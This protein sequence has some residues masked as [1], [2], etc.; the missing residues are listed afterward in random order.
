[1]KVPKKAKVPKKSKEL[2]RRV[3]KSS[4]LS[5]HDSDYH[6]DDQVYGFFHDPSLLLSAADCDWDVIGENAQTELQ[7]LG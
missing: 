1:M 2:S 4:L 3:K 7:E 6:T 5:M